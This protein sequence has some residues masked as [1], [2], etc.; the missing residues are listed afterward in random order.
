MP[1]SIPRSLA[2]TRPLPDAPN[3]P[4]RTSQTPY[5]P[6][7]SRISHLAVAPPNHLVPIA[8]PNLGPS[9]TQ[10][11]PVANPPRTYPSRRR[12]REIIPAHSR[13]PPRCRSP[14]HFTSRFGTLPESIRHQPQPP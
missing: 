8:P 11:N 9:L 6:N 4:P 2:I 5:T 13:I 10:S 14:L 1:E 3:R 12:A 7:P